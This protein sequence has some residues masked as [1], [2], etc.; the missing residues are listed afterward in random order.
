[1]ATTKIR[2]GKGQNAAKDIARDLHALMID[3]IDDR[4]PDG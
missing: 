4:L 2:K 1:M 3:E